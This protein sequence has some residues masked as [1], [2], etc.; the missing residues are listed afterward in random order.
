[1]TRRTV[2][3]FAVIAII[4]LTA[5]ISSV[6]GAQEMAHPMADS[7]KSGPSTMAGASGIVLGTMASPGMNGRRLTEGYLTQPMVMATLMTPRE[8]FKADIVLN[9]EGSTL[10]RGELNAGV[11]GEGYVDRRHPHTLLHELVGTGMFG[12]GMTRLSVTMGKGF[13]PFGTDDPMSRPLVKYP[14]N[15]HLAQLLERALISTAATA[16]PIAVELAAFNGDEPESAFDMPNW[17]RFGDSW[18]ARATARAAGFE[19]QA[20]IAK[21]KSPEQPHGGGLDHRKLSAS[22]R[23][24]R[25]GTYALAEWARTMEEEASTTVFSFNSLLAEG[26]FVIDRFRLF[27]RAERTERPEEERAANLFRTPRPHSDL[28]IIGRTR[29]DVASVGVSASL[30]SYRGMN[31]VPFAE[32]ATQ[33]PQS[34]TTPT[35]FEPAAFY[36]AERL[37]S[38]SIGARL[39][40]GMQHSR[41]GRYGV[42]AAPPTTMAAGHD[43]ENM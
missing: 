24:E 16:G 26:S 6:S 12:G 20:S 2:T 43:M 14:V 4:A 8:R 3:G 38:F 23:F 32:V 31:V 21:V 33:H 42:A 41:M 11:F 30:P 13:V 5:T 22:L 39:S 19:G 18:A 35:A 9:F 29:W 40:I 34:L 10:D 36:G 25:S 15:H 1:M 27:G 37:W 17:D 7:V 28:S